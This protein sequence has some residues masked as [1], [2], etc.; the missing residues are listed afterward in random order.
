M[1][2]IHLTARLADVRFSFSCSPC[3]TLFPSLL[4][5]SI[6][7]DVVRRETN[8]QCNLLPNP[9]SSTLRLIFNLLSVLL[10]AFLFWHTS[11]EVFFC[12]FLFFSPSF[13]LVVRNSPPV[14]A[15]DLEEF[16]SPLAA[17]P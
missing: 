2:E 4:T 16:S 6:A 9:T 15:P 10:N 14:M 11:E 1:A 7:L 13:S 5:V 17:G 12:F 3:H 8:P